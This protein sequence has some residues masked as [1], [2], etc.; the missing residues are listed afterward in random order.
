MP[1]QF[2]TPDLRVFADGQAVVEALALHLVDEIERITRHG[3]CRLALSGGSTP[4]LLYG[5][6]A[7]EDLARRV[8]F[9]RLRIFWG[10]ERCVA[11]DDPASNYLM[12]REAWLDKVPLAPENIFPIDGSLAADASARHYAQE[13]G[14][15]PL[16]IVLLGM[17]TDGHTAYGSAR[18]LYHF[19]IDNIG[20][21]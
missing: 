10:D 1:A 7:E 9:D 13:L 21:Y 20:A 3:V 19:H 14:D 12:A 4:R 18:K 6:L 2:S 11:A 16:D 15:E 8:D 17:G 5:R